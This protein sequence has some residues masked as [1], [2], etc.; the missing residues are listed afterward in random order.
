MADR[1]VGFGMLAITVLAYVFMLA[2]VL[3]VVVLAFNAS[4]FGGFPITGITFRWFGQLFNNPNIYGAFR[5]SLILGVTTAALAT[6]IGTAAAFALARFTFRSSGAM[7]LLLT[8]PILLPNVVLGVAL[9][10][11]FRFFGSG[12]GYPLLVVGHLVMALP[13]VVLMTQHRLQ[14]IPPSIESAAQ[15]LGANRWH[16]FREVTLPLAMPAI[17]AGAMFA[18]MTSFDEIAATLFWAPPNLDTVPTQIM[19][20]LEL[21]VSPEVN[22][23]GTVLVAVT[24]AAPLLAL[25]VNRLMTPRQLSG[26]PATATPISSVTS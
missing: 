19:G 3:V 4:E 18:F 10:L 25:W 26:S 16:T 23:L 14:S 5:T 6:V 9:L 1:L 22:A 8:L 15:T 12:Q 21:Q 11:T 7:Q 24:V 17:V 2:P 13:Y 20:M